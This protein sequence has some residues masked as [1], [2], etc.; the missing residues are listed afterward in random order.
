VEVGEMV[1][2]SVEKVVAEAVEAA[3]ENNHLR[4]LLLDIV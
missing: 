2:M 3:E 4:Q 1:R